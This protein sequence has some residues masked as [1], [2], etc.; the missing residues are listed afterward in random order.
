V[1]CGNQFSVALTASG[2][3]YSWGKGDNYRLGHSTEEHVRF[4]KL[5]S[6]LKG[7]S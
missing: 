1:F 2:E 7:K 6:A 4:P 5:I 3:L